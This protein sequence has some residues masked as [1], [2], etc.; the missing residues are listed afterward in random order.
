MMIIKIFK[1]VANV[2]I[3]RECP[4]ISTK[5]RVSTLT[6]QAVFLIRIVHECF[7]IEELDNLLYMMFTYRNNQNGGNVIGGP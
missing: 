4:R 3:I 6:F 1:N 7:T 2:T 5:W